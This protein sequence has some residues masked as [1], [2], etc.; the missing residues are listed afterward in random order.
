[1]IS[2]AG[3]LLKYNEEMPLP[4]CEAPKHNKKIKIYETK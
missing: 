4:H 3:M 1:M 2:D